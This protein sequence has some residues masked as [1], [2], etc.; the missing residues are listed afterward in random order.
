MNI[1]WQQPQL[2]MLVRYGCSPW[3]CIGWQAGASAWKG[4]LPQWLHSV[5][6]ARRLLLLLLLQQ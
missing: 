5:A 3:H 1:S 6:F 4:M 2:Q